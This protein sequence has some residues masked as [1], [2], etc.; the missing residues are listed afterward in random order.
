[1]NVA[2]EN[3]FSCP[4][5]D[6]LIS[7]FHGQWSDTGGYETQVYAYMKT[8]RFTGSPALYIECEVRMCHG[9]CPVSVNHLR[10]LRISIEHR[11]HCGDSSCEDCTWRPTTQTN[12]GTHT[13]RITIEMEFYYCS[14]AIETMTFLKQCVYFI[15]HHFSFIVWP[16]RLMFI[17]SIYRCNTKC[18][19]YFLF[20]SSFGFF[21]S[22]LL[23]FLQSVIFCRVIRVI[24]VILNR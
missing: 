20:L 15:F 17:I 22:M 14:A 3:T 12:K 21:F 16:M 2:I 11:S 23:L 13:Q 5:D 8:F 1:M 6:K 7:R 4:V 10:L 19:L 24:G 18:N 9:R